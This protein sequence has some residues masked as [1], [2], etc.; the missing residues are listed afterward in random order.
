MSKKYVTEKRKRNLR[1]IDRMPKKKRDS[2]DLDLT[3]LSGWFPWMLDK[4]EKDKAL[5]EKHLERERRKQEE[6]DRE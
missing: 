3:K 1:K 2:R 6:K 4:K 5:W